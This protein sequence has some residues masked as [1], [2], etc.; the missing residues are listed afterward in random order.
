MK[1]CAKMIKEGKKKEE[2]PERPQSNVISGL[3]EVTKQVERKNVQ[4]VLIACD[5][6]PIELVMWLPNL[7]NKY[8]VP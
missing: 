1:S 2:L 7:C 5:T 4:L 6:D 8:E 3:N